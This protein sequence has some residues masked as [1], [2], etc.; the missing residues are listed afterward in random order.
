MRK[1]I[2]VAVLF[3]AL[4]VWAAQPQTEDQKTLYALGVDVAKQLANFALSAEEYEFVRQGMFDAVTGQNLAVESKDYEGKIED[5]YRAR[6]QVAIQKQKDLAKPFLENAAREKGAVTTA[7]GLIYQES[8]AGA[9]VQPKAS[10]FVK[11][12]YT[13]TFIDGRVFDSSVER[14]EPAEFSLS[15]VVACWSEGVARMKVGGKAK[16]VCKSELAYGDEGRPPFIPGGATL[17]FEVELLDV[18]SGPAPGSETPD[19]QP[20][21]G[22]LNGQK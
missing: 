20:K 10:D 21:C 5:L 4:P 14:G 7:S 3:I 9:G 18:S 22:L 12:H 15:K 17:V 11:V 13:G 19:S 8:K 2:I 16:L 6:I 1:L